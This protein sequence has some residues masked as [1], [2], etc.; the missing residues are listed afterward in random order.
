MRISSHTKLTVGFLSLTLCSSCAALRFKTF[1]RNTSSSPVQVI[2][3]HPADGN[4][5]PANQVL[6]AK[7]DL[8]KI[9]NHTLKHVK[10]LLTDSID[11]TAD[12]VSLQFMVPPHTTVY[13]NDVLSWTNIFF[14]NKLEIQNTGR[15]DTLQW[16]YPYRRIKYVKRK[17]DGHYR[18]IY[19]T[20]LQLD[21]PLSK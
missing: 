14:G 17:R 12:S 7:N 18:Y 19:R 9:N 11:A 16:N 1:I 4:K 20:I 13:T 8:L 5:T 6:L 21:V 3:V 15:I 2:W 10:E